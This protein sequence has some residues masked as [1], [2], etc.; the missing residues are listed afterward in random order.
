MVFLSV[1]ILAFDW[2]RCGKEE[3]TEKIV[4][5]QSGIFARHAPFSESA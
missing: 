1:N 4:G 2:N 3:E 5:G